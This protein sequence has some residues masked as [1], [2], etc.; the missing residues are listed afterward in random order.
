M[1]DQ[2]VIHNDVKVRPAVEG[3][4]IGGGGGLTISICAPLSVQGK[5]CIEMLLH[6]VLF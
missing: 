6:F 3:N 4:N 1:H 2:G 5:G